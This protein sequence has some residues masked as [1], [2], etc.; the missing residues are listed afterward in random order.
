MS[1]DDDSDEDDDDARIGSGIFIVVVV[2]VV[3]DDI[4]ISIIIVVVVVVVEKWN[5]RKKVRFKYT[6]YDYLFFLI[7]KFECVLPPLLP[8]RMS[9]NNNVCIEYQRKLK[10]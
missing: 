1:K 10:D 6:L 8:S 3:V 7:R 4:L 2:V 5:T 9:S